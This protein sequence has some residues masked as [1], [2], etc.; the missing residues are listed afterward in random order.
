MHALLRLMTFA[1][2]L[3]LA[4]CGRGEADAPSADDFL[5]ADGADP[6]LTAV[7][8]DQFLTDPN[9]T[10]QAH[11]NTIRP[12]EAPV[13]AQYP[14]GSANEGIPA[15]ASPARALCGAEFEPGAEWARRLPADVPLYPRSRVVEAAG[16]DAG[17]CRFRTVTFE[18]ADDHA[19]LLAYYRGVA[20]RGGFRF[21][22]R[23][24]G[25]DHMLA[26][27]NDRTGTA[28]VLVVTPLERGSEGALVVDTGG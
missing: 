22:Q 16:T 28:F 8:H 17:G 25:T 19:R 5:L 24:R 21:E 2:A 13:Q 12:P 26:A 20:E 27:V 1:I 18:S 4:G 9:L 6:A 7:L 14:P 10:Q 23:P 11:P 15:T 3:A